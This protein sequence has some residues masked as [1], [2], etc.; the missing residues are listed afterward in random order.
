[1]NSYEAKQQARADRYSGRSQ[2][3]RRKAATAQLTFENIMRMIPPGQPILVGH[4]SERRHRRD[5]ARMN[6]ASARSVENEEKAQYY[7]D[8]AASIQ[9]NLRTSRVVSSDDPDAIAKLSARLNVANK[10]QG[11]MVASNKIVRADPKNELTDGKRQDLRQAG[12]SEG[13]IAKLFE[14]DCCGRYGFPDYAL[15]NNNAE[16]HRLEARIALL[17]R[18]ATRGTI[19]KEEVNGIRVVENVEENRFQVFFPSI[20]SPA[21]RSELKSRGFRWSPSNGCWQRYLNSS[22]RW[23]WD[24][25]KKQV[26][27]EVEG[28]GA[29]EGLTL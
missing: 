19:E 29:K 25:L 5:L 28:E 6:Q 26:S 7:A 1:M 17:Q 4:H 27:L 24:D 10:A 14:P 12:I 8:K 2:D 9:E 18:N 16:I 20:P 22:A 15:Q 21:V 13:Q 23:A 3:A 11:M